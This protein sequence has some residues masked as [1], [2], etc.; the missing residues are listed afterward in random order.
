MCVQNL[1]FPAVPILWIEIIGGTPKIFVRNVSA[2]F[3]VRSLPVPGTIGIADLQFWVG[4][5]RLRTP[6]LGEGEAV[7]LR[8]YRL[9]ERW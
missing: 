9:K 8:W 6:N 3:A 1:K 7:G 5:T 2:K 4:V